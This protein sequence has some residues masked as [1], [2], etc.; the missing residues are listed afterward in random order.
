MRLHVPQLRLVLA[1][2]Q[3]AKV[4]EGR[5]GE[6][7]QTRVRIAADREIRR[8]EDEGLVQ[9]RVLLYRRQRPRHRLDAGDIQRSLPVRVHLDGAATLPAMEGLKPAAQGWAGNRSLAAAKWPAIG[10]YAGEGEK[11]DGDANHDGNQPAGPGAHAA[12]GGRRDQTSAQ[13]QEPGR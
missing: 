11:E 7:E 6:D 2:T 10:G 5:P 1:Q 8:V 3:V 13:E 9:R 4:R 12:A